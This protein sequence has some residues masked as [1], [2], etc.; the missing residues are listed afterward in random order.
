MRSRS[1]CD[2]PE[3]LFFFWYLWFTDGAGTRD[4][5]DCMMSPHKEFY[6]VYGLDWEGWGFWLWEGDDGA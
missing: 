5:I 3:S 1:R 6:G 4:R 2:E